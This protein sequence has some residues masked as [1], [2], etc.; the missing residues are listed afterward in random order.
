MVGGSERGW[1]LTCN[2]LPDRLGRD[3]EIDD[4]MMHGGTMF[5]RLVGGWV[6]LYSVV[7]LCNTMSRSVIF[8]VC[9]RSE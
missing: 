5:W 7:M 9:S 4:D 1:I 3:G 2:V 6:V 8:P